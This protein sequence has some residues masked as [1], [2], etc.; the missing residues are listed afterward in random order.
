M[1]TCEGMQRLLEEIR[2]LRWGRMGEYGSSTEDYVDY[3]EVYVG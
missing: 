1:S 2:R 3:V